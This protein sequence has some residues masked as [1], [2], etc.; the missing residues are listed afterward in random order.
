V[1]GE[2]ALPVEVERI[3][4][5]QKKL[6]L[7]ADADFTNGADKG[8]FYYSQDGKKWKPIGSPLQMVYTLEHFMGY[9]FGLFNYA[10]KDAGGFVD[11]DYFHIAGKIE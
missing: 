11:F 5:A 3:P 7:K 2:N 1:I 10:T 4:L 9:R 8:R 6:Y